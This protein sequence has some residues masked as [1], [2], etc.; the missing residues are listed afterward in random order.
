[1]RDSYS[2]SFIIGDVDESDPKLPTPQFGTS[3]RS[4]NF[5]KS[6][7]IKPTVPKQAPISALSTFRNNPVQN[8][9]GRFS[10]D[11]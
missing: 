8:S 5:F 10:K 4:Q 9:Q 1:M 3:G 2:K 6:Q 7:T 11:H